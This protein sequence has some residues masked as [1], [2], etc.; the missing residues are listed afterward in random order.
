MIGVDTS[1]LVAFEVTEHADHNLI[2]QSVA[3]LLKAGEKLAVC[4]IVLAEFVHVAT[5]SRRFTQPLTMHVALER[6]KWWVE[7]PDSV[8]LD[9]TADAMLD[10]IVWMNQHRLG[11]KRII[12]T[13]SATTFAGGQV[14]KVLTLNPSDFQVFGRF[15][16]LP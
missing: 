5:D 8:Y 14:A 3:D 13:L 16:F 15:Q 4:G 1:A 9:V 2:R 11:S 12:D 6:A 7:S 10:M